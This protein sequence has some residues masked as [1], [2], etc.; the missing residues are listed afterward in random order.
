MIDAKRALE[1]LEAVVAEA[2]EGPDTVYKSPIQEG[3]FAARC[4]YWHG[5]CPSC[6][7]G[8]ALWGSGEFKIE[9]LEEMDQMFTPVTAG[10]LALRFPDRVTETAALVFSEAQSL[11]DTGSPWGQALKAA[12]EE[13]EYWN[14]REARNV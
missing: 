8:A 12:R 14:E 4:V 10:N 7:V 3:L 6:M 5:S 9:E 1:L 11:Q 2:P 13:L